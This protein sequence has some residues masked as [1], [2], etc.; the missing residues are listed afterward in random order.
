[1]PSNGQVNDFNS[2]F[3]FVSSSNNQ[4]QWNDARIDNL[5]TSQRSFKPGVNTKKLKGSSVRH[6]V[7]V[8]VAN[9]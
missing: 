5:N 4:S 3:L 1:M 7:D 9:K 6:K 8:S 2:K